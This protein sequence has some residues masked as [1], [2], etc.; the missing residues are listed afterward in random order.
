MDK[1]E[2]WNRPGARGEKEEAKR[3]LKRA[4]QLDVRLHSKEEQL[5][6][7]R[8]MATKAT[9][10]MNAG[11]VSGT[12]ARSKVEEYGSNAV[13]LEAAI[14]QSAREII[15]TRFEIMQTI[16]QVQDERQRTVLELRYLN[17]L[18]WHEIERALSYSRPQTMRIHGAALLAVAEVL[19]IAKHDTQ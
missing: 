13:D 4:Y 9:S 6:A 15:A 2:P 11:R 16:E 10:S 3:Y 1:Q 17:L 19:K 14:K 8:D 12:S 5:R 7:A 18:A